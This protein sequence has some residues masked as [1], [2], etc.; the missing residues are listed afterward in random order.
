M[1]LNS[2]EYDPAIFLTKDS[3]RPYVAKS[4]PHVSKLN[5]YVI[6]ARPHNQQQAALSPSEG[7]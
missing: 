2:H 4:Q 1:V 7:F 6:D 5:N 3:A